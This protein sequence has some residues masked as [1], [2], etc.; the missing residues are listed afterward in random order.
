MAAIVAEAE[1]RVSDLIEQTKAIIT[2]PIESVWPI[3]LGHPAWVEEVWVNYLSNACKYGGLD[4]RPPHITLGA[5][6]PP[7]S[8][9]GEGLIRFWM[10]DAGRGLTPDDRA[11]LFTPFT[12]LEQARATG[13]GLGLSIVRRIVEK[14]GGEVGVESDGVA[15]HGS[16]F[17]FTLP[18]APIGTLPP[19]PMQPLRQTPT[20]TTLQRLSV[21]LVD[22]DTLFVQSVRSLL[23]ARGLQVLGVAHDGEQAQALAETLQPELILMD[24]D[25]PGHN[26]LEATRLIKA[27]HPDMK[28]VMFTASEREADLFEAIR[29][30]ASGYLL[31]GAPAEVFFS[32]LSALARGEAPLSPSL[33]SRV[34]AEFARLSPTPA[35]SREIARPRADDGEDELTDRQWDILERVARGQ[36]YKEIGADLH[37]SEQSIK[38]HM[39][40]IIDRLHVANRVQA[41]A[42]LRRNRPSS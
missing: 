33:A 30:G 35:P 25:M 10:R 20:P 1:E 15:G 6:P 17:Y 11:R 3:V 37:L 19:P 12:R 16:T 22:D 39:G 21:L 40:Q 36:T 31:K 18:A 42:Y 38:Y 28:I 29:N 7:P 2:T 34:L 5:A 14:L 26:G 27:A 32:Q 8:A 13:H 4:G 23:T 24:I 41:V 9:I